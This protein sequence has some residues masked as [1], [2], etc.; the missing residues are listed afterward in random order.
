MF[1]AA[2]RMPLLQAASWESAPPGDKLLFQPDLRIQ[3][4]KMVSAGLLEGSAGLGYF[5]ANW[6][7]ESKDLLHVTGTRV[8]PTTTPT[9]ITR[10]RAS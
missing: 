6:H 3:Y 9:R 2:S 8:P 5:T 7:L 10:A 4:W 1:P